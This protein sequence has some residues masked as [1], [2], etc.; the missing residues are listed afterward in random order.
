MLSENKNYAKKAREKA[1]EIEAMLKRQAR[2]TDGGLRAAMEESLGDSRKRRRGEKDT[3]SAEEKKF[4]E[5]K[6]E[7]QKQMQ[8]KN[9]EIRQKER[10]IA[11]TV[12]QRE[13][14]T[15]PPSKLKA[16]VPGSVVFARFRQYPFWPG[17]IE[18]NDD[19]DPTK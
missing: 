6:R 16:L 19:P 11:H 13:A 5:Q 4:I 15:W 1:A 10:E 12:A 3:I 7:I 2:M 9:A 14:L 18:T 8:E 17:V